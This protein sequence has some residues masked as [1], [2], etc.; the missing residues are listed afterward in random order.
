M[1]HRNVKF[2]LNADF[3]RSVFLS[4]TLTKMSVNN[5]KAD[6]SITR[7]VADYMLHACL[8]TLRKVEMCSACEKCST[9][10]NPR[11]VCEKRLMFSATSNAIFRC[12][13]SCEE[14]VLNAQFYPHLAG[15][16]CKLRE[17]LP[18]VTTP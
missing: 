11:S 16:W 14:K 9:T 13:T 18:L 3:Q 7:Q 15:L 8:A 6:E 10:G 5:N 12:G 1:K 17:K 2:H 4:A